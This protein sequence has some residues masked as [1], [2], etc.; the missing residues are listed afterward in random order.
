MWWS[1]D[2]DLGSLPAE[3]KL[4]TSILEKKVFHKYQQILSLIKGSI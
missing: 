4:L 1:L 3:P 2:L